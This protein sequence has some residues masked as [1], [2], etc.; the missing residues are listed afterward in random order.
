MLL[1][2]GLTLAW[3]HMMGASVSSNTVDSYRSAMD[4]FRTWLRDLQFTSK[5]P[6]W[7]PVCALAYLCLLFSQNKSVSSALAFQAAFGLERVYIGMPR[8][9][10]LPEYREYLG[11]NQQGF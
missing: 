4:R 10:H 9:S 6:W 1:T 8:L 5:P 7:H 11:S 3:S 2:V